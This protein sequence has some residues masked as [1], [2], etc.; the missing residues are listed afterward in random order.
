MK[1][2]HINA[3]RGGGA[4]LCALRISDSLKAKGVETHMIVSSGETTDT[5]TVVQKDRNFWDE[6]KM[7]RRIRN[8][9]LRFNLFY[10][11]DQLERKLWKANQ[12][13]SEHVFS[14]LP[15]TSYKS[16]SHHPLIEEADIVHLH[17]IS[18]FVDYPSFFKEVKKPI[19]WTLHDKYPAVGLMHY[20]SEFFPV[21]KALV[22]IDQECREIKRKAVQG[23]KNL[24]IVAISKLMLE[25]C[26]KSD[27]LHGLDTTLIHNGVDTNIFKPTEKSEARQELGLPIQNED[28]AKTTIF[29]V[30]GFDI[31]SRNKGLSRV[32][33]AL[34][35]IDL[36]NKMLICIGA[37]P[38]SMPD[39]KASFPIKFFGLI[40]DSTLLS[41]LYSAADFYIQ[42]SLEETFAQ[43][44]LEAMSCGTP[45]VLTPCSG[46]PEIIHPYN[47]ILCDG[48]EV[49]DLRQGIQDALKEEQ[50]GSFSPSLIR[51]NMVDNFSYDIIADQYL[52]LY[53]KV[54][55]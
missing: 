25:I 45:V 8:Q 17:W 30:C 47:G 3:T 10:G 49:N 27:I 1:V 12:K 14:H 32:I 40:K 24:H 53:E 15:L 18:G 44:P 28:G 2:V 41:K 13:S 16:L 21:P 26:D 29:M 55:N 7:R 46:A 54:L 4:A 38:E 22:P 34:N 43:T 52:K 51:A 35:G 20:C 11:E 50:K 33:Q 36:P 37:V 39:L 19:V 42:A 5:F 6:T 48:F 9:L 23:L 31:F